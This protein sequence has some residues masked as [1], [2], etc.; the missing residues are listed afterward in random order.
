MS[1]PLV[2]I[3]VRTKDRPKLLKKA[4]Q[5]VVA[6]TYRPLEVILV[7]DG[8]CDL[9]VEEL[10][11]ILGDVTL[12]YQRLENNMGRA[13]A[14]NVGIENTKGK[15]VGFLDDDDVFYEKHIETL[16]GFL[17]NSDAKVAYT[18][19]YMVRDVPAKDGYQSVSKEVVYDRNFHKDL[20]LFQNY[21]PLLSLL[22]EKELLLKETFDVAFD[23]FEDWDLLIR[24]SRQVSFHRIPEVTAE[25][26]IRADN[27]TV[28]LNSQTYPHIKARYGVYRKHMDLLQ[29]SSLS[30]FESLHAEAEQFRRISEEK[31]QELAKAVAYGR[32]KEEELIKV[33]S[34]A[35][36][37]EEEL[38]RVAEYAKEIEEK[39][40]RFPS[41]LVE[42]IS[43]VILT[44]NG[45]L[46][47]RALLDALFSQQIEQPFEV[48]VIDSSSEDFTKEIAREYNVKLYSI[49]KAS[50]SHP[51]TRN[52]G[53]TH[54]S[55]RYIV[56]IT[57]DAIPMN[58]SWLREL[59]HPFEIMPNLAASYSRQIPRSD[60]N[61]LEAK[62]IYTGAPCIDEVRYAD[63]GVAWQR[64]DYNGNIHRYIRFS[65]VSACYDGNLLRSNPFDERLRM[66]EDQEWSKRMID[67]GYITYYASKSV[68]VHSHNFGMKEIFKRN[69]DY[70][71]SFRAFLSQ[72]P[73]KKMAFVK[74]MWFDVMNDIPF[75]LGD[76]RR[77]RS[78]L[79]WICKSPVHRLAAHYGLYK[80]W[81]CG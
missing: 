51:G 72:N 54:S 34:Y 11:A 5:S 62:D 23:L 63:L 21:I 14:G 28:E 66:V 24:L 3:I 77:L 70:G 67:K 71:L 44:H 8:G 59:L 78:K 79:K 25:Y 30:I 53:V 36:E 9:E 68:V 13:H 75:I 22:I 26:H 19:A 16:E 49:D 74:A 38:I 61:P 12:N 7:N 58:S 20:L 42:M 55:G 46:Y 48:I 57:Q 18:D 29:E 73:P 45:E 17:I 33:A 60:C 1:E 65:N 37:K 76:N 80:G 64:D 41:K 2:S 43:I 39:L 4:L 40:K 10:R 6:Q 50:F 27:I 35:R 32:E 47:L 81:R 52:I 15:Y 56:F 31:E 69:F